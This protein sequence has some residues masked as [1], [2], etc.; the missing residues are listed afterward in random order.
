M[1]QQH[2]NTTQGYELDEDECNAS[3]E[4]FREQCGDANGSPKYAGML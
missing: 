3:L 2:S 4:K 1:R